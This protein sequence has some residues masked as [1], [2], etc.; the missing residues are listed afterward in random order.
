MDRAKRADP[1]TEVDI[2][3]NP[4]LGALLLWS[5][6]ASFQ[7]TVARNPVGFLPLFLILPLVIHKPT[8]EIISRTNKS[9]GLGKFCEKLGQK[10]EELLAVHTRALVLRD[11]TLN[12]IGFGVRANL[13]KVDYS[14]GSVTSLDANPPAPTGRIRPLV[15]GSKKIG[16][17][18]QPHSEVEIFKA[19]QVAA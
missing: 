8:L 12:S 4:A 5:F 1:L 18:F 10:R 15:N 7:N 17:W 16:I 2:V 19:L 6:G 14:L 13:L 11:L 3:Q 9:S